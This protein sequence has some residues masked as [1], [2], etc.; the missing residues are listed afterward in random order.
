MCACVCVC[1]CVRT[2]VCSCVLF[3]CGDIGRVYARVHGD[4]GSII[5]NKTNTTPDRD[6]CLVRAS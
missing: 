5:A 6:R 2:Y 1:M 4:K 3:T